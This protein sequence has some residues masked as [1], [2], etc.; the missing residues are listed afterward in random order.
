[1]RSRLLAL[2][3]PLL[4]TAAAPAP[5]PVPGPDSEGTFQ[6]WRAG[7][8]AVT[9]DPA[10]VPAGA[11]ARVA[12]DHT[13]TGVRVTLLVTGLRPGHAYGA[14]LHTG[15]CGSAPADA[16][17]HYQHRRDPAAAPGRPSVD[18]AFANAR[19]EIWLD[20]ITDVNG[21]G[22][23]VTAQDW[24]FDASRPPWSLVLHAEHTHTVPGQAGTAGARLACLTRDSETGYQGGPGRG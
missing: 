14:H 23:A 15:R 6:S 5:E 20:L 3:A 1:M 12:V 16:G 21:V 10:M 8:T 19:N 13:T 9:Y 7:A 22:R 2:A 24:A 17:P 18:P 4:L 11:R